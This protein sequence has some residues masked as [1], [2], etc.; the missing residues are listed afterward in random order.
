LSAG[1]LSS[2]VNKTAF[3][4]CTALCNSTIATGSGYLAVCNEGNYEV[5]GSCTS[6]WPSFWCSSTTA[7]QNLC[8]T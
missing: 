6:M 5:T 8:R 4:N 1:W 2:C 7:M 3:E